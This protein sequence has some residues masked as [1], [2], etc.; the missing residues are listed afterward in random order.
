M[1]NSSKDGDTVYVRDLDDVPDSSPLVIVVYDPNAMGD[2]SYND[3][4]YQGVETAARQYGLRTLQGAPASTTE[5]LMY[6]ESL[7]LQMSTPPDTIRRLL[8]VLT[9]AYLPYFSM[10]ASACSSPSS[11]ARW[12][13]FTPSCFWPFRQRARPRKRWP[14][15]Y[16]G[17]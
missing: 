16:S 7:L 8:I 1:P 11:R 14:S 12:R 6:L 2:H 13:L 4:V 9:S 3:L 10:R 15:L 5:G 17:H